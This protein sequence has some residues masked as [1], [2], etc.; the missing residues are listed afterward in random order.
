VGP[1]GAHPESVPWCSRA[2]ASGSTHRATVP[3]L[4]VLDLRMPQTFTDE[5]ATAAR[6]LKTDRPELGVLLL[7]QHIDKSSVVDLENDLPEHVVGG[8]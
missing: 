8:A 4:V 1:G 7:S 3:D 5:G 6:S 2:R